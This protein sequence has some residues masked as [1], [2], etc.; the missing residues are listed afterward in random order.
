M[1]PGRTYTVKISCQDT[2]VYA[3]YRK[4]KLIGS[5]DHLTI[6]YLCN[7]KDPAWRLTA[8]KTLYEGRAYDSRPFVVSEYPSSSVARFSPT[9]LPVIPTKNGY[10]GRGLQIVT[11]ADIM[12]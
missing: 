8:V 9:S 5:H 6:L 11:G 10:Y 3:Q 2:L 12:S 1:C 7:M 4:A